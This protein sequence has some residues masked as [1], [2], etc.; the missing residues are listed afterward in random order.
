VVRDDLLDTHWVAVDVMTSPLRGADG[1]VEFFFCCTKRGVPVTDARL[2]ECVDDAHARDS[3][4]AR[5]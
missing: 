5:R 3:V 1:N 4:A 2:D